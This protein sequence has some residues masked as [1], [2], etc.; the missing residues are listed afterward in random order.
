MASQK[1]PLEAGLRQGFGL[2]YR[3]REDVTTLPPTVLVAGSKNVLTN[4]FRRIG[5]RRG[6]VLDGQRDASGLRAGVYGSFDWRSH[7]NF[8]RNV[9]VGLNTTGSNGVL[10]SRYVAAAGDKYNAET[11]TEGQV[12]WIPIKTGVGSRFVACTFWESLNEKVQMMLYV[13]GTSNIFA[14][15]GAQGIISERSFASGA[16]SVLNAT[17]TAGGTG[18]AVGDVLTITTGG[19]GATATVA[20]VSSGAVTSVTLLSPGSGYTTGAG[21]ATTSSGAG[22]GA[23]LN[24]TTVANGYLKLSG[25]LTAAQRAFLGS[26]TYTQSVLINGNSYTYSKL[27]GFYLIGLGSDPSAEP[28]NSV[29]TQSV[30]T[31]PNSDIAG[32]PDTFKNWI[33]EVLDNQV[34]VSAQDDN[35]VFVSKLSNFK[36]FTSSATRKPAE[37]AELT[38]DAVPTAIIPQGG[39]MYISAGRDYWYVTNFA[40]SSDNVSESLTV[41]PLKVTAL[42]AAQSDALAIKIKN[43]IAFVS[44]EPQINTLG[45]AANFSDDPQV[46]DISGSVVNDVKVLDFAGGVGGQILYHQKYL[47]ITAPNDGIVLVYNM[48]SDIVEGAVDNVNAHYFEP[49]QVIPVGRLSI[50]S[51]ELYGHDTA[52]MNTYRLFYGFNDD[53]HPYEAKAVFAFDSHGARTQRKSDTELFIE[54]YIQPNTTLTPSL[55]REYGGSEAVFGPVLGSDATIVGQVP[56]DSSLGKSKLGSVPL[57]SSLEVT[58]EIAKFRVTYTHPRVPFFEQQAAFKSDM[59]DG[60]WEIVSFATDT[61]LTTEIASHIKK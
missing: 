19:T 32:L 58:P 41:I 47:Y 6:Y 46:V 11:F 45:T 5:N 34:Y 50:I 42:Q 28:L 35:S 15:T 26:G 25:T 20:A 60:R 9:R 2:G 33:I 8:E 31:V 13:D 10:Q 55:R 16:V 48:T 37:G 38:L 17:P 61:T 43:R 27:A 53:G 30:V 22:T 29:V 52:S 54:G 44:F 57:G 56:D 36:D 3:S 40:L 12:Y 49:P 21:K 14:W 23:T 39:S 1:D 4:T 51:G 18:Y 59:I 7:A 24:I